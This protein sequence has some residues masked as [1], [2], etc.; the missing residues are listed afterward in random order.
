[1]GPLTETRP[2]VLLSV[3]GAPLLE[4]LLRTCERAGFKRATIIV[5]A[6]ADQVETHVR[7]L[8][9]LELDVQFVLQETPRGTGNAVASLEGRVNDDWF[10]LASGDT[11]VAPDELAAFRTAR[12]AQLAAVQVEDA[13][14]FGLL[15][16]AA[17]GRLAAIQEKPKGPEAVPGLVNAGLYRLPNNIIAACGR[18]APSPRGEIELT[19]AIA[20]LANSAELHVHQLTHWLD[21]GRPWDL[22]DV[23]A[24]LLAEQKRSIRGHVDDNVHLVGEVVVEE[25]ARILNGT[26]IEGPVRIG[27]GCKVGPHAYLRPGTTIGRDCHIGASVEIKNSI[28]G[29]RSNVPH[30]SYVGDSVI[31]DDCNLGAGSQVANLKLNDRN[32]RVLWSGT[33]W[34]DSGRRK[35]GIVAG[36]DVKTGINATLHPGTILA[37]GARVAAGGTASGWVFAD[38]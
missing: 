32:V 30:L 11:L 9:D 33:E 7:D 2:K 12:G 38:A 24:A 22:L 17:D 27:A 6:G 28:I 15:A 21:A 35:L 5:H 20:A 34:V 29:N 25:G 1:M 14:P 13:R 23:N 36:D 3:A 4:H 37:K 16:V 19:D 31:G 26:R 10:V 8:D 18:L